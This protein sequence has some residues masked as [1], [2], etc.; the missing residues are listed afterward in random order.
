MFEKKKFHEL[1]RA[2]PGS[3]IKRYS[4]V[5]RRL[6]HQPYTYRM[7]VAIVLCLLA[8]DQASAAG[9]WQSADGYRFKALTVLTNE[10]VGFTSLSPGSTGIDFVNQLGKERYTTNQ[11]YLNGAGVAAGDYDGDGMC[12]LFFCG[13]DSENK[14]Y[15]NLGGW[16]FEDVSQKARVRGKNIAT[17]GASFT[18]VNGN[19]RLDLVLNSLGQGTWVL[20]NDGQGS[21]QATRPLNPKGGG[22]SLALADVDQDGDLDLY[23]TNYRTV[24]VRDQPGIK[25]RGSTIDGKP[26]VM[27]INGMS[28]ESANSVGR[29]TLTANGKIL[30]HG[31]ADRLYLNDGSGRFSPVSFTDGAFLDEDG[32]RLAKSPYDW[33][34]SAMFRDM[35]RDG[36]PDLYVCNDFESPDRI[37]IN[38]GKGVFRAIDRLAIRKSSHFSMGIDFADLNRDGLD[39]FIVVDMLSRQHVLRHTQLSNRKPPELYFGVY[40]DRPQYSYNTVYL[41]NGD[42][43]YAEIGFHTNLAATE[44]SWSPVFMDVDLD[45]YDDFLVTT[46][47]PLDMQDMD[48]TNKGEELKQQRKYSHRELL[49]MRFMFKPLVLRNLAF[50]NQGNL[51]F[52]EKSTDWGFDHAGISHGMALADLDNDGDM[53]IAVNNFN[54]TATVYRNNV[55]APRIAVNLLGIPPNTQGVGARITVESEGLLQSQEIIDGGRYLSDDEAVRVFAASK[56]IQEI[57]VAWPSGKVSTVAVIS[58][59]RLYEIH[60]SGAGQAEKNEEIKITPFFKDVS[61]LLSH[62]HTEKAFDDFS[63]Q[64]LLP[65]KLSQE[66]PGVAWLDWNGDGWDDIA[67]A[68][69]SGGR[70]GLFLSDGKGGFEKAPATSLDQVSPRDQ[71]CILGLNSSKN[72][73]LMLQSNY[74]D[75]LA[76]GPALQLHRTTDTPKKLLNAGTVSYSA[77]CAADYDSDGDLDLF[78]G[79]RCRPGSYPSSVASVILR[80][81]GGQ[82]VKDDKHAALLSKAGSVSAAVWTDLLGD[83]HP[84]LVLGCDPGLIRVYRNIA[85][86]LREVTA[87]LG[88]GDRVGFWNSITA[89]DFNGDGKMDLI[90]GNIG[91][92]SEYELYGKDGIT[93]HHGDLS[94][95][96]VHEVFESYS[97]ANSGKLL[98]IRN[99]PESLRAIPFLRELYPSYAAYA[100]ATSTNILGEQKNKLTA[101]RVT[102]LESVV[103]INRGDILDVTPL[104]L[105]VQ[106]APVFGISVADFDADGSEDLFL[107]QN[108]FGTRPD[109]P[110]MD[111]GQG[112]LLKGG[113]DGSFK[114]MTSAISG[115][116]MTGEQRGS[117]VADF[118]HDGRVDLLAGQNAGETKLYVNALPQ[119]G[120]RIYLSG[121]NGNPNGVGAKLRLGTETKLGPAREV[122]AGGGYRSQDAAIQVLSLGEDTPTRLQVT[123]PNGKT[124]IT[125]IVEGVTKIT[126]R[127]PT[128]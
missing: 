36:R 79:G 26:Q 117:A 75:G 67:V 17:T 28:L 77:L 82:F 74:E 115:I 103:M 114:S 71:A 61:H 96:G 11:I 54:E 85:G 84:E 120:I 95:G 112:L 93:W 20:L 119:S 56:Q 13:L 97:E 4:G 106:L 52:V 49:E 101:M 81:D 14:L 91:A 62:K 108:F 10:P 38:Q 76:F 6:N 40:N 7:V 37:W 5:P 110:R 123:W 127:E 34:L 116:R 65:R 73:L 122:R 68:T 27:S 42:G 46:G 125:E 18:D 88:L 126:V 47:H 60:E 98:P 83:H 111:A 50:R 59:N 64:Q 25:L 69:G 92:N 113:G 89:G 70:L 15:R 51:R 86:S 105:E 48:V 99:L 30:E 90:A 12:D 39:E 41:N 19:G 2:W 102:S 35:N 23:V 94:G 78:V 24:T 32:Q 8:C 22:M 128:Q 118:D 109:F 43:T 87:E 63:R 107:A 53:D 55:P 45:G 121:Q 1:Q 72:G 29:F 9:E 104:P 44:W 57:N 100:N 66:G 124:T 33:G 3:Q 31:Q 16:R 58:P 80:N 21:F